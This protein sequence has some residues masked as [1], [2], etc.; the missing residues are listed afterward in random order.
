MKALSTISFLA[1]FLLGGS[2]ADA[3][4]ADGD[5]FCMCIMPSG[6]TNFYNL[7]GIT[8]KGCKKY[9]FHS[10]T[11][12]SLDRKSKKARNAV[13]K[14]GKKR[15]ASSSRSKKTS[16]P[17]SSQKKSVSNTKDALRLGQNAEVAKGG[18]PPESPFNGFIAKASKE[19]DIPV[20]L[21]HAVIRVESNY[22]PE[23]VS[24]AGAQGL[25]Q[26][27]PGTAKD[28]K[29]THPFDPEDNILGGTAYLRR[30]ANHYDG[31]IV[32]TLAAYHAG[33][34]AVDKK[35]GIPYEQTEKYV[36]KVLGH[37]YRMKGAN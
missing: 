33:F 6:E 4:A 9:L 19:H 28:M 3:Q 5:A 36:K 10:S 7:R 37:Y 24:S 16:S 25:M 22:K 35:D 20:A 11:D 29:V 32:K 17:S 18:A 15:G 23:A 8:P 21:I 2:A 27:M 12:A 26:L 13:C 1:L 30:L 31:D 14:K 34:R